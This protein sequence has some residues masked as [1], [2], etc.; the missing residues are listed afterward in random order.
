MWLSQKTF[1]NVVLIFF[2]KLQKCPNGGTVSQRIHT[3][4]NPPANLHSSF[5]NIS[6]APILLTK[7]QSN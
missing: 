6:K 7:E 2:E 1:K 3:N 5:Q 4:T